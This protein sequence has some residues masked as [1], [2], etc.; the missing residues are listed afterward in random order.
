MSM[1]RTFGGVSSE[2]RFACVASLGGEQFYYELAGPYRYGYSRYGTLGM[3]GGPPFVG[4]NFDIT[5]SGVPNSLLAALFLG[6]GD[7]N[8]P[9]GVEAFSSVN[10][11][12]AAATSRNR[13]RISA[14]R[15]GRALS[16][17]VSLAFARYA[18]RISWTVARR[19][20][21]RMS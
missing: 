13:S 19:W 3:Q 16:G 7:N 18:L 12:K 20:T 11:S 9:V 8:L 2:A 15:P 14:S 4:A 21:P 17:C 5:L 10:S 6:N 1:Y